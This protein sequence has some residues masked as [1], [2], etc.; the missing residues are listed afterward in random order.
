M[1]L[2]NKK[3]SKKLRL[4]LLHE[5]SADDIPKQFARSK[6]RT[7]RQYYCYYLRIRF[8]S[9][10]INSDYTKLSAFL[11]RRIYIIGFFISA[12]L[13]LKISCKN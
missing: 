11:A 2:R 4:I 1:L 3:Q 5:V 9:I 10:Q 7:K 6:I 8:I 12:E 13:L